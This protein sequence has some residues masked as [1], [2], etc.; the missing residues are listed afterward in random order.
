[1]SDLVS[2]ERK[3]QPGVHDVFHILMLRKY[4]PYLSHVLGAPLV[5]LNKDL[6]FKVQSMGIMDKG[7]KELRNKT[8][9]M[10]KVLWRSDTIEEK[11]WEAEVFIRSCHPYLFNT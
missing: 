5:E 6:T 8:I 4:V 2:K 11:T 3:T 7:I 9:L 10:L 1:M